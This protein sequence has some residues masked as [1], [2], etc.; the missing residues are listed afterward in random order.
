M[1]PKPDN[2]SRP[3]FLAFTR[4]AADADTLKQFALVRDWPDDC[5]HQ[6]DVRTAT[7]FL[8]KH[9]SPLLLLVELP[10]AEEAPA[11]LDA[12]ADVCDPSTKVITTGSINEYSFYCWLME[13]GVS[14]YLLKPL[15]DQSL[16]G[17]WQKANAPAAAKGEKQGKLIAVMGTRGGAGAT[18]VSVNLAGIIASLTHK[19]VALLDVDPDAG[20]VALSL[21]LEPSRGLRDALEKPDR[22]D[23]LFIERVM[24][25][26]MKNL[27]ILS[28]EDALGDP[29]KVHDDAA[30][31]LLKET[32]GSFDVVIVDVPRHLNGFERE[33]LKQAD[34]VILVT[35][36]TLAGLR[37][38][39]RLSD[40]MRETLK[41]RPPLIVANRVGMAS[42]QETTLADFEKGVNAKVVQS[43]KFA[44]ELFMAVGSD[45]AAVKHKDDA[46]VAPLYALAQQLVPEAR[47]KGGGA[48]AKSGFSLFK[49]KG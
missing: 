3:P 38:T 31:I 36:M 26:P 10:S 46:A 47:L 21:D 2:A 49:K 48:K 12:L 24:Q 18:L 4:D 29:V 35:E 43:V 5:V 41:T 25:K 32:R 28:S 37:D 44:P 9:A 42:K 16:E 15:S 8:K 19:N 27:A 34:Q 13:L 17:A 33:C 30:S 7:D 45:I 22:I 11:L 39:L 23:S 20:S 14:S 1:S 40:M 6:G